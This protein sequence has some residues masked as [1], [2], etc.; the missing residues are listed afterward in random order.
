MEWARVVRQVEQ[1]IQ[2][3]SGHQLQSEPGLRC[4]LG[5]RAGVGQVE[6]VDEASGEVLATQAFNSDSMTTR[7]EP[8]VH[9]LVREQPGAAISTPPSMSMV[10]DMVVDNVSLQ[11][12]SVDNPDR[13]ANSPAVIAGDDSATVTEDS[14]DVLSASGT[15]TISDSDAG[16]ARFIATSITG[17]YGDLT[18]DAS[19]QWTY[20]ADNSQS[21][22]QQL[23]EET[24]PRP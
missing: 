19:G 15:L 16:E 13:V 24:S 7:P 21:A 18:L 8:G 1:V 17:S 9:R 10:V 5:G 22:I 23:G 20:S 14:S 6:V 3:P 11:A 2:R 4:R 12:R